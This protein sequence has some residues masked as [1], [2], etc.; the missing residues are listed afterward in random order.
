MKNFNLKAIL[1]VASLGFLNN[2]NS[3]LS[4]ITY[5]ITN[6]YKENVGIKITHPGS[7]TLIKPS[8]LS[9]I[10]DYT[11]DTRFSF[12]IPKGGKIKV[13]FDDSFDGKSVDLKVFAASNVKNY[14]DYVNFPMKIKTGFGYSR[15][16]TPAGKFVS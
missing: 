5:N 9:D 3:A 7:E 1:L 11:K 14:L 10:K 6:K 16:I 13:K 15:T 8:N 4:D 12:V 2:T